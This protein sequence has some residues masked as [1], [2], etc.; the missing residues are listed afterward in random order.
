MCSRSVKTNIYNKTC[1]LRPLQIR[2]E[3]EGKRQVAV[4]QRNELKCNER[5]QIRKKLTFTIKPIIY[6]HCKIDRI[7]A[8]VA[9]KSYLRKTN[10]CRMFVAKSKPGYSLAE[11]NGR[12]N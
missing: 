2:W 5:Y 9:A 11:G 8:G 6:V 1:H 4:Q 12:M 10:E 3:I 7:L